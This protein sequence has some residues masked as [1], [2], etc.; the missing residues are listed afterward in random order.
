MENTSIIWLA[1]PRC[2]DPSLV[3]NKGANLSKLTAAG[4]NVPSGFC[5]TTF[6]GPLHTASVEFQQMMEGVLKRFPGPW[7]VRS[8][9]T[10]EDAA[11]L[12]F[13]GLFKTVLGVETPEAV[14]DAV[15]EVKSS[16]RSEAL[17]RYAEHHGVPVETIRVGVVVQQ[18]LNPSAAGVAFSRHPMTG[19]HVVVIDANYGLGETVVDGSVNPDNIEVSDSD[20][21]S[22]VRIGSKRAK[23]LLGR[24]GVQRVETTPSEQT[25]T[26]ISEEEARSVA[27]TVRAVE[28]LFGIPQDVEWALVG[29][30]IYTVQTRPISTASSER[31][32]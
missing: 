3:G 4:F 7:A 26:C 2:Q 29:G 23:V 31:K 1:D 14:I 6:L 15:N 19:I 9:S 25:V 10:A 17:R 16:V 12:S 20:I 11:G 18:L 32:K 21:V 24:E 22:F 28:R 13:P 5:L 8:S 30:A 27:T